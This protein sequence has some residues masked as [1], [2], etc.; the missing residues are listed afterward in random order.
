M[1]SGIPHH[2]LKSRI[3]IVITLVEMSINSR[4]LDFQQTIVI[5]VILLLIG[6]VSQYINSEFIRTI[7]SN[8]SFSSRYS[9]FAG[10]ILDYGSLFYFLTISALFLFLS[11]KAFERRRWM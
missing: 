3:L 6:N 11:T 9:N 2:A 1:Q 10:G 8:I 4:S 5:I 7:L